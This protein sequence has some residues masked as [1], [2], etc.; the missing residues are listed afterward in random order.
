[1]RP[2][3]WLLLV[4]AAAAC[5]RSEEPPALSVAAV[6]VLNDQPVPRRPVDAEAPSRFSV[7]H[8]AHVIAYNFQAPSIT[9]VPLPDGRLRLWVSWYQQHNNPGGGAIGHSSIPYCVYAYCDDPFGVADPVWRRV[10]YLEPVIALGGE[11]A[12]DPE[13]AALPDGRM[14][15]SYITSG[16]DRNRQRSTYAFLVGNPAATTGAFEVGGQHWLEYG[17]LSQPFEGHDHAMFA[18]I[19]QWSV[20]RR[21][22]RLELGTDGAGDSVRAVRLSEIPWPGHPTLTTFFESSVHTVADGR[23]RAYRRTKSGVYTVL[24]EPGG[25]AWGA[26]QPWT[27]H[28]SVDSRSA[29]VRSP[30]SGRIVGAVNCPPERGTY[31]TDL[32]LVVSAA[33][34][35]LGSFNHSLNIEPDAGMHKVASQYPRLAFDRAGYVYCVYRWSDRRAGA[36]HQGAAIVVARVREEKL[37][38]GTATLADVEKRVAISITPHA[39]KGVTNRPEN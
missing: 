10:F 2:V 9:A 8:A 34:G 28:A 7:D 33:E 38:A 16:P 32:T 5:A 31:R 19:D 22:C 26:E 4:V 12:S 23:Y 39:A 21:F 6:A 37:V 24:S 1:M 35:A 11:T 29:F 17:V 18:A 25:L 36:P 20:A 30:F 3:A 13:V 15:C 27:D 14:L